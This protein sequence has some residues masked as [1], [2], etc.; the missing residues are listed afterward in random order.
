M[1]RLTL[2][3][4]SA[5]IEYLRATESETD[6]RLDGLLRDGARL[7]TTDLV[8]LEVL[9]GARS[10]RHRD[11]MQNLLYACEYI[12]AHGPSDY[13]AGADVYRV[14]RRNGETIRKLPDCVIAAVA[15]RSGAAL[16]HC[17]ADFTAISRHVPLDLA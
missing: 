14:C 8:V 11:E 6:L 10:N 17:D 7:A 1:E 2:P 12:R 15:M 9:A 5:W 3:D 16:L 13:E 4:S